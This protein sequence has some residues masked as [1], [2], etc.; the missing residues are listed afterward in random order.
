MSLRLRRS[1]RQWSK[2]AVITQCLAWADSSLKR[3]KKGVSKEERGKK[4]GVRSHW[5][6]ERG[7]V[8]LI[9]GDLTLSYLPFLPSPFLTFPLFPHHASRVKRNAIRSGHSRQRGQRRDRCG[10]WIIARQS[11]SW[12]IKELRPLSSFLPSTYLWLR[13]AISLDQPS[14]SLR[15]VPSR[16]RSDQGILLRWRRRLQRPLCKRCCGRVVEGLVWRCHV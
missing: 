5:K 13:R 1:R 16:L 2:N 8:S 4:K 3:K 10:D 6:E 11:K 9:K 12:P 14:A 15:G 7:Q